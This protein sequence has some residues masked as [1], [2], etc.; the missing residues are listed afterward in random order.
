MIDLLLRNI[1]DF[2]AVFV[3]VYPIC[4]SILWCLGSVYFYFRR[5]KQSTKMD[6]Y[7]E[8]F[9]N[10]GI[11]VIIPAHNETEHIQETIRGV[12]KTKYPKYEIIVVDDMSTDDTLDKIKSLIP[13]FPQLRVIHFEQ[14]KGKA[15]ALNIGALA[16]RYDIVMV[17]DADAIMEPDAMAYMARHFKYGPRVGAVTGNPRVR[18]RTNIIE[19]IQVAEYSSIIGIIK[20]TQRILGKVFTISGV[21]A[22]FR[23]TAAYDVGLWDA[24]MIT[25]DI[26]ITW[27]LEKRF[28]DIRY[29]TQALCWTMVPDTLKSLWHQ[30]LRWAQ[31]GCEVL[32]RHMNVWKDVRQRRFWPV[33]MEYFLSGVWAYTF[34]I[35][36]GVGIL[37]AILPFTGEMDFKWMSGWVGFFLTVMCFMQFIVAFSMDSIYEKGLFKYIFYIIWYAVIYWLLIVSTMV[38]AVVKVLTKK[39]NRLAVW[40]HPERKKI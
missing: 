37:Y 12:A 7:D 14:N 1:I 19:K 29:E 6:P 31:G 9:S 36:T 23:K 3:F 30:R 15:V 32:K 25:D 13:E 35:T 16:S 22:A 39:K 20:R 27:K 2:F 10:M 33:Y 26:N 21:M 38:V 11:T 28:W 17:L 34:V 4:M 5:E 24:D 8:D 40:S 18:N